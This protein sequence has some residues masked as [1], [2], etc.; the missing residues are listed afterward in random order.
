MSFTYKYRDFAEALYAALADDPF[1]ITLEKTVTVCDPKEGMLKYLEYSM[2]EASFFGKLYVPEDHRHGV[3]VWSKPLED[4]LEG[5]KGRLKKSFIKEYMGEKSLETYNSIVE[6]MSAR[7]DELVRADAW[8]L[9]IVG[10]L[11][12]FQRQG[13]G[14]GLVESV[15]S[16]ID[17]IKLPTYLETFTPRNMSFY[18]RLGYSEAGSFIEPV[19]GATY[20]V[21]IREAVEQ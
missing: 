18:K 20:W 21:M 17:S 7:S 13:L 6:F 15:L 2:V 12:E 10:V 9:S 5:E 14:I 3:S 16:E 11:P 8:Y 19:T 1:Y 4:P